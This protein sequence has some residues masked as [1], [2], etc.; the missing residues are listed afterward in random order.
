MKLFDSWG[1]LWWPC[2][3]EEVMPKAIKWGPLCE[4]AGCSRSPEL[5]A[6]GLQVC[7]GHWGRH[8]S[9]GEFGTPWFKVS[10]KSRGECAVDGCAEED[11]G[12]TG[13]CS[14]H[15][16][17]QKRHGDPS[18]RIDY[19]DRRWARGEENH[20]WTGSDATYDA[21]HQ[22]LRTRLGPARNRKCV[23]CGASA[24]QWSYNRSGGDLEKESKFG[25]YSTNLDDYVA[26]C[27]PC[28]KKFD[29]DCLRAEN[30]TPSSVNC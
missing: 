1:R 29:L 30:V 14:K 19:K 16:A 4:V 8:H 25:P 11:A 28:H 7:R 23:D 5:L 22:R 9:T 12:P 20:N 24:A 18:V 15:L 17:R 27:V 10:R 3:R 26:R 21:V 6:A 2:L 13:Y